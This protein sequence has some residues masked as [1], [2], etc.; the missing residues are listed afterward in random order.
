MAK[1]GA[2]PEEPGTALKPIRWLG[3]SRARIREFPE[4]VKDDMGTALQWAQRGAKH[5]DAKPLRGFGSAGVLEVVE[6]FDGNAY[7]AVYTVKF[8]KRIYV[9]HVFQKK[10]KTEDQTPRHDMNLIN[11]RLKQ[12]EKAE[13]NCA[14]I[15]PQPVKPYE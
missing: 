2:K 1:A 5:P 8:R 6:N 9:L 4:D 14:R 3:D 13:E 10:S 7:R 11:E 15:T 12:A